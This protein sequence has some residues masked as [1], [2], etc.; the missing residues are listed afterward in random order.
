MNSPERMR[1]LL[2]PISL[3]YRF[4]CLLI[5]LLYRW[6][7]FKPKKSPLPVISIGN[8]SFGGSEKTPLAKHILSALLKTSYKPALVAR[9]YRG[10]WER[11]GGMLSNGRIVS[12]SW[13]ESG[14]EPFMI[15]RSITE[16]GIFIGKDRLSGCRKAKEFGFDIVV[17]DDAFQYHP[18]EKDINILMYDPKEK[19]ILRE[20]RSSIGR[21]HAIL[22]KKNGDKQIK[23]S[24]QNKFPQIQSYSYSV[25]NKGLYSIFTKQL[26]P[27]AEL[28][29]KTVLLF[30]GI[31]R[32]QRFKTSL[33]KLGIN[34][35]KF[36][37]FPDH[38]PYP[39]KSIKKIK[40][41]YLSFQADIIIT[42]EKDMIKLTSIKELEPL[43]LYYL[44]I[45]LKIENTFYTWLW[46]R[47]DKKGDK[48]LNGTV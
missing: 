46:S 16:A 33:K 10:K 7:F 3:I 24:L 42:T 26:L 32:P 20:T 41:N 35:V 11:A 30:S 37:K 2:Y 8:I 38:H 43:P 5:N 23:S 36:L 40:K 28:D 15:A 4:N 25:V 47:L 22:I 1:F 34:P 17:L 12:G 21:S 14:D 31:A 19:I 39:P 27:P 29:N 13:Q 18:L 45:D 48:N 6:R 44:K 9:G